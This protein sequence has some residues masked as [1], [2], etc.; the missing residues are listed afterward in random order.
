MKYLCVPARIAALIVIAAVTLLTGCASITNNEF[1]AV[2]ASKYS[3]VSVSARLLSGSCSD[4]AAV[5]VGLK[6]LETQ[7]DSAVTYSSLKVKN[8]RIAEVGSI[9]LSLIHEMNIRYETTDPSDEYCKA[10]LKSAETLAKNITFSI[11][12]KEIKSTLPF[13][14]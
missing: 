12:K 9:L 14:L 2:E 6:V 4:R 11:A 1:D 13:S 8:T 5:L 7:I 3:D 10:K